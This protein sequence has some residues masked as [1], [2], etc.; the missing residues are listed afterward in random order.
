MQESKGKVNRE[1]PIMPQDDKRGRFMKKKL[2][3]FEAFSGYGSQSIALRNLGIDYDVVGISEIDVDAIIAYSAIRN[4]DK[5]NQDID[6]PIEDI[7]KELIS[8]NIGWDFKKQKS[9]IPCMKIDKLKKLYLAHIL[10][11]NFG[12]ISL[13]DSTLIP[14]H[15]LF[16]YSFPCQDISVAGKQEGIIRGK[17]VSGLLYECEKIIELK[18]P[19]FLLMENVKNLI[20][21]KHKRNFNKWECR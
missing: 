8:K 5:L 6:I 21:K 2:R 4:L 14:D 10:S 12:D 15:D 20:G 11:N 18:R 16:I 7:K 3:V 1:V 19:K 17:T 9:R 13:I